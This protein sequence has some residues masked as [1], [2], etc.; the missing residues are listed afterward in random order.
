MCRIVVKILYAF[1]EDIRAWAG[2]LIYG[3][4]LN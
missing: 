4:K 3:V 2:D 1:Q